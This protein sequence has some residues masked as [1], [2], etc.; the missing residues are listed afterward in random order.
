VHI[1][2]NHTRVQWNI[3]FNIS[4]GSSKFEH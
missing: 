4:L 3:P 2:I 1:E